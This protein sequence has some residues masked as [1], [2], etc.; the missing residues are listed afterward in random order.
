MLKRFKRIWTC[1]SSTV[2]NISSG[3][4]T[5]SCTMKS[6]RSACAAMIRSH[7]SCGVS[8]PS[9]TPWPPKSEAGLSTS[10]SRLSATNGSRS[11][12]QSP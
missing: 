2:G 8:M 11:S 6:A 1:P 12:V 3:T 9:E 5:Y 4:G 10:F 7:S